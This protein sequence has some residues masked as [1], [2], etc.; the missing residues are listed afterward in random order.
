VVREF[1]WLHVDG[2]RLKNEA[3]D[4][5]VLRGVSTIDVGSTDIN[6]GGLLAMIDR[7]TDRQDAQGNSRGWHPTVIR[8][9]IYPADSADTNSPFTYQQGS[10][11]FYERLLRPAVE[12]VKERGAYAIVDWHYIGDTSAHRE[13]TEDFWTNIA[14]KFANDSNVI[15]ELF[16]EPVNR[17]GGWAS[18]KE[19]MQT[20]YDIVHA[21][22]PKNLVLV[23]TPNWCQSLAE[24]ATEPLEGENI[25]YVAH[26]YPMHFAWQA[27]LD[28]V[29]AA[30]AVHPVFLTEWG[31]EAGSNAVVDGDQESYGE[32][33]KA[34]VE[35][36]GMSTVAWCASS[37]WYSRM[38]DSAG[39]L[40]VGSDV[41]GGFAKD[42]LYEK[43]N[44]NVPF[45]VK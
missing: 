13:T 41:M 15:F 36:Q 21:A 23:G 9:A 31:Y 14:P 35:A 29:E 5:V 3:G 32:P 10:D 20:W 4:V 28:G 17:S 19:D 7:V 38:F 11:V 25:A 30:N 42:W 16:N 8:L 12:R 18:V 39:N 34:W 24:T 44:E 40:L 6:E 27:T 43:R 26:I 45:S 37:V 1:P 22:A 2:N 33:Y